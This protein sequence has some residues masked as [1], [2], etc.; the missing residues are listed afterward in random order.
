MSID[1]L[2]SICDIIFL[3]G[4]LFFA[5]VGSLYVRHSEKKDWNNGVCS[6]CGKPWIQYTTDSHGGRMYRC[7]NY[8]HCDISY[9]VD[10]HKN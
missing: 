9:N 3:F 2:I 7:E 4:L 5:M 6:H 1:N 8:H 10:K